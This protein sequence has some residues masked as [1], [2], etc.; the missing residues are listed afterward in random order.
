MEAPPTFWSHF[1][2]ALDQRAQSNPEPVKSRR[3]PANPFPAGIRPGSGAHRALLVLEAV[4]PQDLSTAE[5][6]LAANVTRNALKRGLSELLRRGLATAQPDPRNPR[7]NRY[8]LAENTSRLTHE[9][10]INIESLTWEYRH[11]STL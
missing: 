7:W 3:W 6:L 2:A 11:A 9:K 8:A 4:A 1:I 10:T 5:I